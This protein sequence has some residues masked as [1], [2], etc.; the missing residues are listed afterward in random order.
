MH[1]TNY[2][3]PNPKN[4][5][6]SKP[7]K[8]LQC[9]EISYRFSFN[10]KEK[11]NET[12]GEGNAYDFGARIYDSR[13]GRWMSTDPHASKYPHLSPYAFVANNPINA[14]DPDGRDIIF[15]KD[16]KGAL[17]FGH[18]A[19]LIGNKTEGWVY[20]SMNGTGKGSSP[21]GKSQNPDILTAIKDD[22]GNIV[23]DPA[24][25]IGWANVINKNEKH[26]YDDSKRIETS[27]S[28]DLL[29]INA[30]SK[31]AA[32]EDYGICGPGNNSC[33]DVSQAAFAA[34]V[35]NRTSDESKKVP[36]SGYLKPNK[37]FESLEKFA[38]K[39]NKNIAAESVKIEVT[40]KCEEPKQTATPTTTP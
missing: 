39:A 12:Y 3:F 25:A 16:T 23:T 38:E 17:G 33:I 5:L 31:A 14:I 21:I 6:Y 30:A 20:I 26:E 35:K 4:Y 22:K 36:G 32:E 11:D 8:G 19:V 2:P 15:L 34:I 37:W 13:L 7:V 9:C 24:L 10:G 27:A 40:D 18:A 1:L 28:E 29:A